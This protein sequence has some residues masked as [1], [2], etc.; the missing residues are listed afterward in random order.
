[1]TAAAW[2]WVSALACMLVISIVFGIGA[3]VSGVMSVLGRGSFGWPWDL[4]RS[5]GAALV[6]FVLGA[7]AWAAAYGS[8]EHHSPLR[9]LSGTAAGLV[10]FVALALGREPTAAIAGLGVAWALAVPFEHWIRP[11]LRVLPVALVVAGGLLVGA[12]MWPVAAAIAIASPV[13]AG[14]TV[15]LGDHLYRRLI[16]RATPEPR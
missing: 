11:L 1:M 14:F 4:A 16:R 15:L 8:A 6:P 10:V 13:V 7:S 2:T 9:A 5:V 12:L 3:A